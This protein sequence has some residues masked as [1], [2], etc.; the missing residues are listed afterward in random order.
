MV[1]MSVL[2]EKDVVSSKFQ[3]MIGGIVISVSPIIYNIDFIFR[4]PY[5]FTVDISRTD[6]AVSK[7]PTAVFPSMDIFVSYP[8]IE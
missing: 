5:L 8:Q 6:L 7:L 1:H 4:A 3:Y 2:K